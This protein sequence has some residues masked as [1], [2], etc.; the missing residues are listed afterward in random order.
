VG[1]VIGWATVLAP[2]T[3]AVVMGVIGYPLYRRRPG[4]MAA[5][6]RT[7][8]YWWFGTLAVLT[9][10]GAMSYPELFEPRSPSVDDSV[11]AVTALGWCAAVVLGAFAVE[12]IDDRLG[13]P[14]D[15]AATTAAFVAVLPP[16][17]RSSGGLHAV[18]AIMAALEELAFRALMLGFLLTVVGTPTA[19]AGV[20]CAVVFGVSHWWY[21]PRQVALKILSGAAF[22]VAAL[23]GGWVAALVAHVVFNLV[24][25]A[26]STRHAVSRDAV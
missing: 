18:V 12:W 21:G 8:I 2:L 20:I 15:S 26:I 24:V 7:G 14:Q 25:T 19:A 6:E 1:L 9:A 10:L 23:G 16:F 22:T 4:G 3:S 13:T 5:F 17:A 11:S